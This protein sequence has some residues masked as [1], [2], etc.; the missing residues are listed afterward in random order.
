MRFSS[1]RSKRTCPLV[2]AWPPQETFRTEGPSVRSRTMGS[3]VIGRK[4]GTAAGRWQ[5]PPPKPGIWRLPVDEFAEMVERVAPHA[6][7]VVQELI[8]PARLEIH[9]VFEPGIIHLV[10]IGSGPAVVSV[11]FVHLVAV[12]RAF[13]V[14]PDGE[15][16]R[17][18]PAIL[19]VVL[20]DV[21]VLP[22]GRT[23]D[24]LCAVV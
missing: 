17:A 18:A 22:I 2:C 5:G 14:E 16:Q 1:A 21:E 6:E 24:V 9:V 8:R 11:P 19:A 15:L 12:E 4:H 23:V 7:L 13:G 20:I 3:S 10:D